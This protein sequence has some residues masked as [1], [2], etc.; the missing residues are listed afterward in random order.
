[1]AMGRGPFFAPRMTRPGSSS[2]S[3]GDPGI[4]GPFGEVALDRLNAGEERDA[5]FC[6]PDRPEVRR[7]WSSCMLSILGRDTKSGRDSTRRNVGGACTEDLSSSDG[8]SSQSSSP[9]SSNTLSPSSSLSVAM[10]PSSASASESI[11]RCSTMSR[12]EVVFFCSP[13][14]TCC[15]VRLW[16][17]ELRC[18]GGLRVLVRV[19]NEPSSSSDE[20][21]SWNMPGFLAGEMASL[22]VGTGR[23]FRALDL[24]DVDT[25]EKPWTTDP[26]LIRPSEDTEV[27]ELRWSLFLADDVLL[28]ANVVAEM[29]DSVEFCNDLCD[30]SSSGDACRGVVMGGIEASMVGDRGARSELVCICTTM[31]LRVHGVR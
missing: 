3:S 17:S 13:P 27:S 7:R 29:A 16:E 22:L 12:K 30:S 9:S 19:S 8:E 18:G 1:M 25:G 10:A 6:R 4:E 31:F 28:V 26:L 24:Y 15:R 21:P 14:A 20:A 2:R 11:R 23:P 5:S